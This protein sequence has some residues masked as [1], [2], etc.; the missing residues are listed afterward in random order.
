MIAEHW[1]GDAAQILPV[2]NNLAKISADK[3][4][5]KIIYRDQNLD[6]IDAFLTNGSRS[7]PKLIQMTE[8]FEIT[9]I[10]GPRPNEAQSMVLKLKSDPETAPRYAEELHLWYAKDKQK[11]I[12]N[13]LNKLLKQAL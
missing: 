4:N 2:L 3:I 5:F 9:G 7:I 8:N 1:C 13:E 10:W 11:A 6:L 12:E